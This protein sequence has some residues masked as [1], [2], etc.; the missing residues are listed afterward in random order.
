MTLWPRLAAL[1]ALALAPVLPS[2][3]AWSQD[4]PARSVRIIVPFGAGGPA[5][6]FARVLAQHLSDTLKQ[7]CVVEDRPGAGS[8]LGTDDGATVA[9]DGHQRLGVPET[10]T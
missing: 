10:P 6:V 4:Y 1:A 3:L 8:I 9:P 7:T 5:D 2:S